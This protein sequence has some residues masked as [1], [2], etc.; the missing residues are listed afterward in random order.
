[1]TTLKPPFASQISFTGGAFASMGVSSIIPQ[2]R[3]QN[4]F[5]YGDTVS[6]TRG[7]H[8]FKFG[9]DIFRYQSPSYFDSNLR[10][11]VTFGDLV[12]FQ[13]GAPIQWTQNFGSTARHNFSLDGSWFVQD[14]YRI[15]DTLTANLGF[16][17]ESAGGV[18]EENNILS[19]LNRL[20]TQPLGGGGT[21]PLGSIVLGG[22]SFKR[23]WNPAP[24]VGLAWNPG[25]GKLV[26]RAGY[27][28]AYD[29]IFF[30]PITN[31]RFAAPFVPSITVTSFTGGNTLAAL[32]AG[33][34]PAQVAARAAIGQFLSTQQNFG[35]ISPVDLHIKNPRNQQWIG[36]VEYQAFRDL[37]VKASYIHTKSDFLLA[38]L[39]INPVLT[40]VVPAASEGD[41]NA[42]LT[43][44][45]SVFLN[46]NG[47][48]PVG[49]ARNDRLDPRLNSVTQVLG[50]ASSNYN[51]LQVQAIKTFRHGLSFDASYTY[52]HSI[53][54]VSDALN[55]LVN[56]SPTVQ[57]PRN[58]HT[59]RGNSQFDIRH[60][61]VLSGVYE[62]PFAKGTTGLTNKF[63]DGWG[64]SGIVES[65]SGLPVTIF[66]GARR[67]VNDILLVGSSNV[68][69]N[70]N[71][72]AFHPIGLTRVDTVPTACLR[73]VNTS[74]S[75]TVSCP[76]ISG[77][78]L[79]QPLL[80]N[81][82]NTPRNGLTLAGLNNLNLT[83][84]KNTRLT[85][86]V[87]FQFRWEVYNILNHPN[88]SGFVNTL[89]SPQFGTYQSTATNM[90]Q[91][92]GSV[93]VI[94]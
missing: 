25:R 39:Q 30:N 92:Q 10:G 13:T 63:L 12:G 50:V 34:A 28:M 68:R 46:Q 9:G 29:F 6:W 64:L 7:R 51:A 80:G 55:V 89:T 73:G 84:F 83:A 56:D 41:E 52:A 5:Q 32:V 35:N 31:L 94:F 48:A 43:A 88:P 90:R 24:R 81:A 70:G 93:K 47:A 59:N 33:T 20:S 75:A 16:R 19:N 72:H 14:D 62:F 61:F 37:V 82:G 8:S 21:G 86:R 69:A 78:P 66:A 57:D 18:S 17:L 42:R 74:T 1:L 85:E 3:V 40:P 44:L 79:F 27:G 53:D 54:N 87:S 11:T 45:R 76:N 65:R 2:G 22:T 15:T 4:T 67:G 49:S 36:G 71:I 38:S 91:M 58:L 60:R 77:F 23:T 26:L